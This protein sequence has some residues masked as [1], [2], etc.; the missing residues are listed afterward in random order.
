MID[1]DSVKKVFMVRS[2]MAFL[3]LVS[4][5]AAGNGYAAETLNMSLPKPHRVILAHPNEVHFLAETADWTHRDQSELGVRIIIHDRQNKKVIF[6]EL[7]RTSVSYAGRKFEENHAAR[8][9]WK[10]IELSDAI[11]MNLVERFKA[12]VGE[13]KKSNDVLVIDSLAWP[14]HGVNYKKVTNEY[15]GSGLVSTVDDYKKNYDRNANAYT[16]F[17]NVFINNSDLIKALIK[18]D[19]QNLDAV[20]ERIHSN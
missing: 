15:L 14:S 1:T 20:E 5:A 2:L 18:T 8:K 16:A 19:L 17:V 4:S 12:L 9:M 6:N 7:F 13:A 3:A 10:I 11:H